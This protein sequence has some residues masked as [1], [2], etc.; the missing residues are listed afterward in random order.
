ME[1][2]ERYVYEVGRHLPRK[3]R[4]DIQVELKS[5]LVDTLEDRVEGEP[6]QDDEIQ[7]LKEFGPPR[8]VASF[9]LAAGSI[10]DR[11]K[12]FPLVPHGGC[13]RH[14]GVCHRPIGTARRCRGI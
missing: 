11:A 6:S 10:P 12:S 8:K 7:L 2:I 4:A 5:T 3:Q 1:L 14:I 9:L 13:D